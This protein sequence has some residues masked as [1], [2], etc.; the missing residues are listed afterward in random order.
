MD[1]KRSKFTIKVDKRKKAFS[2]LPWTFS[3]RHYCIQLFYHPVWSD[4]YIHY[5]FVFTH[6]H[7]LPCVESS[8][9]DEVPSRSNDQWRFFTYLF[10]S[11]ISQQFFFHDLQ[12]HVRAWIKY[13]TESKPQKIFQF[14]LPCLFRTERRH[15]FTLSASSFWFL[16]TFTILLSQLFFLRWILSCIKT[17]ELNRLDLRDRKRFFKLKSFSWVFINLYYCRNCFKLCC[18]TK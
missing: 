15:R 4:I 18:K 16:C 7:F 1:V 11:F 2:I 3:T 13:E 6:C 5:R 8:M 12:K 10:W 9:Q 17:F 14:S